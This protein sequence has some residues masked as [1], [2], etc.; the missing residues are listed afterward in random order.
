[1]IFSDNSRL[2][3][4]EN[5][6]VLHS[7]KVYTV[8]PCTFRP[9]QEARFYFNFQCKGTLKIAPLPPNKEWKWVTGKVF[10]HLCLLFHLL[11]SLTFFSLFSLLFGS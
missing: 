1:M 10:I 7:S 8:I 3:L 4:V 6:V 9:L 2:L 11:H 5:E